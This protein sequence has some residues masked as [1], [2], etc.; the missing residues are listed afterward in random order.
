MCQGPER[1]ERCDARKRVERQR[2][3]LL[4]LLESVQ[5]SRIGQVQ[6]AQRRERREWSDASGETVN[7]EA[8]DVRPCS[9]GAEIRVGERSAIE[10]YGV[11]LASKIN[12]RLHWLHAASYRT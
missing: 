4:E 10:Q 8:H 12:A 2:L 5:S 3:E 1:I 6:F 7:S 9:D 11:H